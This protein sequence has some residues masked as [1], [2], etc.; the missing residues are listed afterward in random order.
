MVGLGR[1]LIHLITA[2]AATEPGVFHLLGLVA[3]TC[4]QPPTDIRNDGE[5]GS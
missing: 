4:R 2:S 3:P 5:D 1:A